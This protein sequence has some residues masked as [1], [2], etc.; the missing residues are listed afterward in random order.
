M[1]EEIRREFEL[2]QPCHPFGGW[3]L[4]EA[5][6]ILLL[7]KAYLLLIDRRDMRFV[8]GQI[9]CQFSPAHS[10]ARVPDLSREARPQR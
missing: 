4:H 7:V 6:S 9:P 8:W 1:V 3:T 10:N 5:K 2:D